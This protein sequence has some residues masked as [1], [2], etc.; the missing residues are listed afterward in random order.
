MSFTLW[1]SL[2]VGGVVILVVIFK[3][4]DRRNSV[5]MFNP[6][7]AEKVESKKKE[8]F[9]PQVVEAKVRSLFPDHDA[10]E[11]LHLLEAVPAFQGIE[12]MKLNVLKLSGGNLDQ[13]RHYI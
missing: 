7:D 1:F 10:N 5:K 6:W 3:L 12:R 2:V 4:I 9:R 11:I 8:Y 13:L